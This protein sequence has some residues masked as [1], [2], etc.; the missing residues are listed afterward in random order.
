MH[1]TRIP[2]N[3]LTILWFISFTTAIILI[4]AAISQTTVPQIE[5]GEMNSLF[6]AAPVVFIAGR[7]NSQKLSKEDKGCLL[8][9][10]KMVLFIVFFPFSLIFF[11]L[12]S[13]KK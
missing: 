13:K 8:A 12:F 4:A 2:R 6:R 9:I 11:I 3:L 7:F 10:G 5:L 1:Q